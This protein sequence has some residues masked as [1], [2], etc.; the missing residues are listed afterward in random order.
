M[1]KG[2]APM[3]VRSKLILLLATLAIAAPLGACQSSTNEQAK[4]LLTTIQETKKIKIGILDGAPPYSQL[5][6]NGEPEGYDVDIAK[7]VAETL[8]ATP[9]FTVVDIPGRV[10]SL[11]TGQLDM[12]VADFT[13]TPARA[14]SIDFTMPYLII[15]NMFLV[16]ADS[17][18]Q[19]VA[20]L[21]K[22]E[23]RIAITRGGTAEQWV[24]TFTP[25][26]TLVAFNS[27]GDCVQA[28]QSNQ[29]DVLT[30]DNLFNAKLMAD[31]PGTYRVIEE[32]YPAES[33]SI[34]LPQ[35]DATWA[36]WLD[37]W[38]DEFNASGANGE[39]FMKWFGYEMPPL[40]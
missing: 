2:I 21:N 20:D 7:A 4:S 6:A 22:P 34:G 39:L 11:Q 38:V 35:G 15:Q 31:N 29:A 8:G 30:Q 3:Q 25:D 10:T 19:T 18:Y 23:V 14:M 5:G 1:R 37:I 12:V 24:P 16:R 32:N 40:N 13:R 17:P 33:I 27:E 36:R 28:L 26:A 9:T